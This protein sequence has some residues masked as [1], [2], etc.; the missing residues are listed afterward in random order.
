MNVSIKTGL[1]CSFDEE[2]NI[3][4][5]VHAEPIDKSESTEKMEVVIYAIKVCA[6]FSSSLLI[7]GADM[8]HI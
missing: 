8:Q 6:P 7:G 4:R 3:I 2:Q 5:V 1:R